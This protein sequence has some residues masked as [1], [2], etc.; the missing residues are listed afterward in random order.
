LYDADLHAV[1]TYHK[2]YDGHTRIQFIDPKTKKIHAVSPHGKITHIRLRKEGDEKK[3]FLNPSIEFKKELILRASLPN[4][5]ISI[6]PH[7]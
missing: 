4:N 6:H 3:F 1:V 2:E 5:S 7:S